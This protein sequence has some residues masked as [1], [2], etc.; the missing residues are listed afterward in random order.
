[1]MP[2]LQ[3]RRLLPMADCTFPGTT[4]LYCVGNAEATQ[5]AVSMAAAL[6]DETPVEQNPAVAQ[7]Q[8]IPAEALL[9]PGE[10]L[11]L[12]TRVFNAIGTAIG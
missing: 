1:M 11:E 12:T 8:T 2:A 3:D 6:G 4:A 10:K 5:Q 7:V 9:Y